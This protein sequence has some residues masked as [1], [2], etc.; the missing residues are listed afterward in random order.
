V[1]FLDS[2]PDVDDGRI[3]AVGMSMGGE[4][5][6][7]AAAADDRIQAVIAEGATNRV[8]DDRSWLSNEFGWRGTIQE[9]IDWLTYATADLLTSADPPI[10]LHEAVAAIAPRRVMLIAA[11][12]VPNEGHADRYIAESSPD[13]VELW[14]VPDTGHTGA[15]DTHPDDWERRVAAFLA[16]ALGFE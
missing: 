7:G 10:S 3:A 2:Q 6:I 1:S 5:A 8:A 14:V 16:D 12:T 15:L 11:G 13:T 9:G 4:E